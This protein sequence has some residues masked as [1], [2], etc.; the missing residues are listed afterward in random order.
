[1]SDYPKDFS[2]ERSLR[3]LADREVKIDATRTLKTSLKQLQIDLATWE[4]LAQDRLAWRRSVKTGSATYEANRITV[5]KAKRAARKSPAPQTNTVDAQALLTCP[6][7]QR[8]FRARIGHIGHLRTQCNNDSTIPTSTSNSANP[9]SDSPTLTPV[10]NFITPTIIETT[11][12]YSSPVTPTTATSTAFD[13]AA[14]TTTIT[15]TTS[16]RPHIHLAHEPIRSHAR[17]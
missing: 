8:M 4:D 1:M 9:P 15:T 10:I 5:A 14:V 2:A 6:R 7:S 13:A 12:Q 11:S 17:P 3:V 16:M